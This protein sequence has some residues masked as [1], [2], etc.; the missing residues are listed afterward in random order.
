MY[1]AVS[2]ITL[3]ISASQSLKSKRGVVRSLV[4]R[5]RQ[6]FNV[7][8]A[9]TG[10]PDRWQVAELGLACVSNSPGHATEMVDEAVRFIEQE[11]L[12]LAEVIDQE[13]QVLPGFE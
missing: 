9:E 10:D 3:H 6:R 1:V 11:I 4:A 12:G 5:V 7:A 13:T 8:I 2:R